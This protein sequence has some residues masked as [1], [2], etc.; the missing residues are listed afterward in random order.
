LELIVFGS[1]QITGQ[2]QTDDLTRTAKHLDGLVIVKSSKRLAVNFDDLIVD[3][4]PSR[5]IGNAARI[6]TFDKDAR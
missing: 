1:A 2:R 5:E 3:L 6:N 4:N